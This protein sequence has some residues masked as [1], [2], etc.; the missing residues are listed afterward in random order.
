MPVYPLAVLFSVVVIAWAAKTLNRRAVTAALIV[1]TLVSVAW[2]VKTYDFSGPAYTPKPSS[3]TKLV[4]QLTTD[5]DLIVGNAAREYNLFLGRTVIQ[6]SDDTN[7]IQLTPETISAL[8]Y[9]WSG[10]IGRVV[11]ALSPG[12]EASS[13]GQ[14]AAD[15]SNRQFEQ[16]TPLHQN[17]SLIV[18][19]ITER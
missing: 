1:L 15:L 7:A 4:A 10:K 2:S 12:L 11:L 14:F 19:V 9:R 16:W 6:I 18:Y 3:R 17:P 13:Y 8:A 5:R